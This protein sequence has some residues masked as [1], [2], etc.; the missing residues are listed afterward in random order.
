MDLSHS[1]IL[2][3]I[4]GLAEF[5]PISSSGHLIIISTIMNGQALPMSFEVALHV[6]T[7]GALLLYF[8]RDWWA[9]ALGCLSAVQK[10][11]KNYQSRLFVNL[12]IGTIPAGIIGK[13]F[14]HQIESFFTEHPILICIPLVLVGILLWW[15][16]K[17][18]ATSRKIDD[19]GARESFLVGVAQAC[20]LFPG[21]SRSGATIIAGRVL[22]LNRGDA[23]RFSFLLGTPAMAG[24]AL[25]KSKEILASIH[26]PV[27]YVGMSVSLVVG[28]LVIGFLLRF[29]RNN[30]FA[31]FAIY[32]VALAFVSAILLFSR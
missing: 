6:G 19:F 22:G 25:L 24:A 27:F 14:E 2:G 23:A 1:V 17:K 28:W 16:D 5:L 15:V 4:Q 9:L 32:R 10:R 11:Q 12:V 29:L 13:L 30:G 31:W 18:A 20:A 21:T 8:W 7:L 3:V 26:Q